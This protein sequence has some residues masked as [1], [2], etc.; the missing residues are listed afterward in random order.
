MEGIE[1]FYGSLAA[2]AGGIFKSMQIVK[3]P[4]LEEMK[5][6]VSEFI[7]QPEIKVVSISHQFNDGIMSVMVHYK[8]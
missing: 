1:I 4:T 6:E 2:T 8:K 5:K 7:S 3:V